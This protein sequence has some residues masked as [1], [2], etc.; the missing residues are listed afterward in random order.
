MKLDQRCIE[1]IDILLM[2]DG[3]MNIA[4][5][6]EQVE[7]NERNVRYSLS[8]IDR[9]MEENKLEPLTRHPRKGVFLVE[10]KSIRPIL[11][12][13][14]QRMTPKK[15][16]YSQE[17]I[18]NFLK[19]KMLI[20]EEVIPTAYFE[21]V[22]FL[23][24]TT[25]LNHIRAIEGE[26]FLEDLNLEHKKRKGHYITGDTLLK[27]ITFA[28]IL[29][30]SINIREFYNFINDDRIVSKH[31][32]LFFYNLF[33]YE[34]LQRAVEISHRLETNLNRG[35]DDQTYLTLLAL[36]F[37]IVTKVEGDFENIS[38]A[39]SKIEPKYKNSLKILLNS[40]M[41]SDSKNQEEEIELF[42]RELCKKVGEVY[43]VDFFKGNSKFLEQIKNHVIFM[44]KRLRE[45]IT[46]ENPIFEQFMKTNH[47]IFLV[48][49]Q[50][51][52]ELE[53][54]I[55]VT[56]SN[57]E[58]SFLAIYFFSEMEKF[59]TNQKTKPAILIVCVEGT[60]VASMIGAQ[61]KKMFEFERIDTMPLRLLDKETIEKYDYVLSTVNIPDIRSEKI[62]RINSYLYLDDIKLLQKHLQLKMK[63]QSIQP[64]NKFSK[65]IQLMMDNG[66]ITNL[67]KLESDL[68][69][70]LTNDE[71][72]ASREVVPDFIFSPETVVY[73]EKAN[74][75]RQ[76]IA[77]GT[78]NLIAMDC[79]E[80]RYYENIM[81]SIRK[82][83]S[84][85]TVAP[86]VVLAHAGPEDGVLQDSLGVT[87]L[88]KGVSF[89]DRYNVPVQVIFTMAFQSKE[90]YLLVER[91]AQLAL[92][93]EKIR[94]LTEARSKQE[95]YQLVKATIV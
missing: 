4:K 15:Y 14:K 42:T 51:C 1:I 70:V 94:L 32:E 20:S 85:M 48:T 61:I 37:K 66:H 43:K 86:G 91:L 47:E 30:R 11:S 52:K 2:Q 95:I 76:A 88:N 90:A 31:G 62:L 60:A 36:L 24:R 93:S 84:Y 71:Y 92:N 35:M 7:T 50:I 3:Y 82:Y 55:K 28:K 46:I 22:L 25:I 81:K 57:Q 39:L 80:P 87:V 44:V 75:W 21:E 18:Q 6:A 41:Q 12:I 34:Y 29:I 5:I 68:L 89:Y 73:G 26:V 23:S 65:I 63:V 33:E 79:I 74:T 83:G 69:E 53:P 16:Q 40:V 49:S 45:N 56:V 72:E 17:E 67:S 19:L 13:F 78:D 10:K 58:I 77:L 27:C 38:N 59:K 9:F 8:K 54:I 64:L